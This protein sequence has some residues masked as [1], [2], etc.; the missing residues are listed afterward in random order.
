MAVSESGGWIPTGTIKFDTEEIDPTNSFD[1][2]SGVF[3]ASEDGLF[4]FFFN[5]E[6]HSKYGLIQVNL[7]GDDVEYIDHYS[8]S[9]RG[10]QLI[11]FWSLNL[12][13]NDQVYINNVVSNS[14]FID[15]HDGMYFMGYR[16]K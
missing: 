8:D 6:V 5:A 2:A 10:R 14:T 4:M 3:E 16:I 12:K 9:G 15:G 1:P 11:G 7:N 13:A